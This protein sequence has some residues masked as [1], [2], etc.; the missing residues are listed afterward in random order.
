MGGGGAAAADGWESEE[1]RGGASEGE[2]CIFKSFPGQ[3]LK[4]QFN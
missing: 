2:N 3:S 1:W 4:L